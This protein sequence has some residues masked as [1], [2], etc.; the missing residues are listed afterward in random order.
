MR[1]CLKE[2]EKENRNKNLKVTKEKEGGRNNSRKEDRR[3]E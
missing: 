1:M 2:N 3:E